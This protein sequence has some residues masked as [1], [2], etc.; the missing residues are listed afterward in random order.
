MRLCAFMDSN[1]QPLATQEQCY[2]VAFQSGVEQMQE[3]V[4]ANPR[5]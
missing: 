4:G 1:L 2:R 5:G 3:I